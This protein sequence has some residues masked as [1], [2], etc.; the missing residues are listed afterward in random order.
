MAAV[1][2][3]GTASAQPGLLDGGGG[4]SY[5]A[6]DRG[7]T[8]REEAV[9]EHVVD[10]GLDGPRPGSSGKTEQEGEEKNWNS[11]KEKSMGTRLW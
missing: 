8:E 6:P 2:P 5:D 7:G 1:R 9:R 3:Q 10:R 11:H 4:P